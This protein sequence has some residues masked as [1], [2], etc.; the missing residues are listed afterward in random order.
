MDVASFAIGLI[1]GGAFGY[2][3]GFHDGGSYW[4]QIMRRN[5]K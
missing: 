2:A 1:V 3:L 4:K 5:K